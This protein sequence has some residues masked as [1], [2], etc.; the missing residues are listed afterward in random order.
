MD[1]IIG[2]PTGKKLQEMLDSNNVDLKKFF[3][4]FNIQGIELTMA[5]KERLFRFKPNKE[6]LKWIKDLDYVSIHS[7]FKLVSR[8]ENKQDLI[9]QLDALENLYN[10]TNAQTMVIHAQELPN[11]DLL[12][13]YSFDIALENMPKKDKYDN[14]KITSIIKTSKYGFCLDTAHAYTHKPKEIEHLYDLLQN[15][16]KQMHLSAAYRGDDHYRLSTATKSF[17][18]ALKPVLK[19]NVPLI[20]E[21]NHINH[22]SKSEVN[23]EIK[24]V[25]NL[26]K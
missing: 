14:K 19:S 4:R 23:N 3:G 13:K 21:I 15:K 9:K 8:S 25:K 10:K 5:F 17:T 22:N 24:Y 1:N 12:K 2:I 16:L 6:D 11:E 18:K 7:P 20:L 26:F